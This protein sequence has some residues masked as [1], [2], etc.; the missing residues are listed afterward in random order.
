MVLR[1]PLIDLS[2]IL[3]GATISAVNFTEVMTRLHGETQGSSY[4]VTDILELVQV[5]P[6]TQDQAL[7]AADLRTSTRRHGLSLGDRAC[8][9]LAITSGA[10]AYTADR[11]WLDIELPCRV[12]YVRP[13]M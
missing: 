9:A 1:E 6:F 10:T 7:V 5:V 12:Q 3:K 4:P 13:A 8:L 11:V 2:Q